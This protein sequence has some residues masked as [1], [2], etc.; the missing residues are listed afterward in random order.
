ME[1]R[2]VAE[3]DIHEE[4]IQ[5]ARIGD[6]PGNLEVT[7][8]DGCSR[9]ADTAQHRIDVVHRDVHGGRVGSSVIVCDRG[10]D[11]VVVGWRTRRIIVQ[12]LVRGREGSSAAALRDRGCGCSFAASPIDLHR[13]RIQRAHIRDRASDGHRAVL[14]DHRRID[15]DPCDRRVHVRDRRGRA[16][17]Y[18]ARIVVGQRHTNGVHVAGR[19]RRVVVQV[20]VRKVKR[21]ACDRHRLRRTLAPVDR[22][23]VCV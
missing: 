20:L 3:V 10:H 4:G 23:L 6:R 9:Y 8:L 1:P 16:A 11:R 12:I 22:Q 13:V 7:A 2:A 19:S 18:R 15:I 5:R 17:R 14:V 21:A